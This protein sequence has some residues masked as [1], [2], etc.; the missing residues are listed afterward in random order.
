MG[1]ALRE[2]REIESGRLGKAGMKVKGA[3]RPHVHA[4]K[5]CRD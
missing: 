4:A 3:G 1:A 2:K 5:A